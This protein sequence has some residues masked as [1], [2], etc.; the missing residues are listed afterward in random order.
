MVT[1]KDTPKQLL[2][3]CVLSQFA[4]KC[5]LSPFLRKPLRGHPVIFIQELSQSDYDSFYSYV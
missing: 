4:Q 3:K 1:I 2:Y 5:K